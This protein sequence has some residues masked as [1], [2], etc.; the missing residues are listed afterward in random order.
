MTLIPTLTLTPTLQL[1]L[2]LTLGQAC[3]LPRAHVH[4][5]ELMS[6]PLK[7]CMVFL[8]RFYNRKGEKP[9]RQDM[10]TI[11]EPVLAGRMKEHLIAINL[12]FKG[13]SGVK[14]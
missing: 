1:T 9:G 7:I 12:A 10:A 14:V 6:T 5:L 8:C 11:V 2:T 3:P 4:S 13:G